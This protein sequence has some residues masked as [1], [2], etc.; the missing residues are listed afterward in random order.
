LTTATTVI[1]VG[2][3]SVTLS[4]GGLGQRHGAGG[5]AH[6]QARD[7]E[8]DDDEEQ[9]PNGAGPHGAAGGV[10][11]DRHVI[12]SARQANRRA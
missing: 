7:D 10:A 1:G 8:A 3:I 4:G 6:H 9:P 5:G 12:V 11:S 2:E